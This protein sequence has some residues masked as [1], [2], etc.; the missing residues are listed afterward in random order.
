MTNDY[1]AEGTLSAIFKNQDQVDQ[2]I[3]RLIDRGVP[4]DYISAMGRNFESETRIAGA[5]RSR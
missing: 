4:S 2:A 3:R 1:K 5:A